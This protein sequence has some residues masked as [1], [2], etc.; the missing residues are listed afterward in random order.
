MKKYEDYIIEIKDRQDL[1]MEISV[2]TADV[3]S[4]L[5]SILWLPRRP[6]CLDKWAGVEDRKL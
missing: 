1:D 5:S 2:L 3:I 6:P 4:L